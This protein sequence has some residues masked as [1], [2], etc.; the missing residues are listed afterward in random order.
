MEHAGL[1]P[2]DRPLSYLRPVPRQLVHRAAVSEVFITDARRGGRGYQVAA[3]WPRD[4]TLYHPDAAGYADPLLCAETVRQALVYLAHTRGGIPL[5]HRFIGR[6]LGFALSRPELTLTGS[7]PLSVRLDAV[8]TTR[9]R[10]TPGRAEVRLDAQIALDGV[11]CGQAYIEALIVDERRYLLL[12]RGGA[13]GT[14]AGK[15]AA[16]A[17]W[18]PRDGSETGYRTVPLVATGRS[19]AK[20]CL[21]EQSVDGRRWRMRADRNHPVL[22]DHPT[23]HVPLMVTLEGFRQLGHVITRS[24]APRNASTDGLTAVELECCGWG[25]LDAPVDLVVEGSEGGANGPQRLRLAALQAGHRLAAATLEWTERSAACAGAGHRQS[26][27]GS[28]A[29][30]SDASSATRRVRSAS[31]PHAIASVP[32][33][34]DRRTRLAA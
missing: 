20:D 33:S 11:P 14:A 26:P 7:A 25:E 27:S 9:G 24:Y 12:R 4:H 6:A 16:E 30:H 15:P 13:N 31:P 2:A 34:T 23:D 32:S 18:P 21:L 5:G 3:Q 8:W 28:S 29:V 10:T 22:F 17:G 19:R 1:A